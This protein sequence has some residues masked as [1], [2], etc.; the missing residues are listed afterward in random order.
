MSA[1]LTW[2]LGLPLAMSADRVRYERG[3]VARIRCVGVDLTDDELLERGADGDEDAFRILV[4]RW[5]RPVFAFLERMLGSAEDAQDVTQETFLRVCRHAKTYR[6]SGQFK[7]WV[8][9]IAGNL[10][11]S[12]LRRRKVVRWLR[13]DPTMHDV[14]D[15]I[16]TDR[17]VE[18]EDTRRLVRAALAKLPKRQ[19]EAVLLR[20]YQDL[21]YREIAENLGTS[22]PAV[23]SLIHRA[24]VALQRELGSAE[25]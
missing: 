17:H 8:F 24:M 10:A 21:S 20:Q 11:R 16:R 9:R 23:E 25:S 14:P 6:A 19:R 5:E 13:F 4:Q 12:R 22:V 1:T 18:S 3:A 7:S 15:D 2:T